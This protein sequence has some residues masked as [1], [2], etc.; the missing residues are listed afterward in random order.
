MTENLYRESK[1]DGQ[2]ETPQVGANSQVALTESA[3]ELV[4][5]CRRSSRI[6]NRFRA[7]TDKSMKPRTR[8]TPPD[9][10][11]ST[12]RANNHEFKGETSD[13]DNPPPPQT[14]TLRNKCDKTIQPEQHHSVPDAISDSVGNLPSDGGIDGSSTSFDFKHKARL[15]NSRDDFERSQNERINFP[16]SHDLKSWK[17]LDRMLDEILPKTFSKQVIKS[18]STN[19]LAT[20]FDSVLHEF[21]LNHCGPIPQESKT[22]DPEAK[23]APAVPRQVH[24]GLERLRQQKKDCRA[25]CRALKKA[26]FGDSMTAKE[27]NR[28]WRNLVR[29]HNRLRV[30]LAHKKQHK[31]KKVAERQFKADPH[32]FAQ[33]LFKE[34]ALTGSPNASAEEASSFFKDGYHDTGRGDDIKPLE[35]MERPKLPEFPFFDKP[36]NFKELKKSVSAKR[37]AATP[38]M[39]SLTYLPYKKCDS[40]LRTLLKIIRKIFDTKDVPEDWALAFIVLLQKKKDDLSLQEFRPIAITNTVGKIFF[41]IISTRLQHYLTRNNYI[42]SQIQKGF[43]SGVP[44]CVEHSFA[45]WE[46]LREAKDE[47]RAIVVSWLDLANAFG[48]VRHNLIQFALNWYHVPKSIQELIFNYYEKLC[49]RVTTKNWST[50]FFLFDIGLFQGCVLSTILFDCVFQLLLDFLKPLDKEGYKFKKVPV[51]TMKKAYADDLQITTKDPQGHQKVLDRSQV[52]FD[53]TQT[54]VAKPKKCVTVAFRQFRPGA[55]STR[56][57]K[58]VQN[59]VYSAYNPNL[60]IN[61]HPLTFILK[62]II[63]KPLEDTSFRFLGRWLSFLLN[64]LLV[65]STFRKEYFGWIA[66]VDNCP[67]NGCMKLWLYQ[68]YV[69][70]FSSWP[71]LVHDFNHNFISKN[72]QQPTNVFLRKWAGLFRSSDQGALYRPREKLGLGLTSATTY[73]RMMQTVKC[74]LLKNSKDPDIAVLYQQ[75]KEREQS[76]KTVWRATHL[77]TKVENIVDHELKFPSVSPGDRRGLGH[78]LFVTPDGTGAEHRR[79]CVAA[80]KKLEVESHMAHASSLAMQGVWTKWADDAIPFDLSWR[81][82]IWGPGPRI[83]SFVINATINSLPTPDMLKLMKL[84]DSSRCTLC[85]AEQC[86]LFHILVNCNK[87]LCGKRYTWR[88]DSVIAT[89][90]QI[91]VPWLIAQNGKRLH[92]QTLPSIPFVKA[93]SKPRKPAS[94]VSPR[95]SLLDVANDWQLLMDFDHCRMLF[96][97]EIC[98]TSERPDVVIWSVSAKTV[99]LGELTCPAEE[100]IEAAATRKESRYGDLVVLVQSQGWKCHLRTFESGARGFVAHSFRKFFKDLGFSNSE[101]VRACKKISSVTARCSYGIWLMRKTKLWNASR[102]LIVPNDFISPPPTFTPSPLLLNNR[103]DLPREIRDWHLQLNAHDPASGRRGART[104]HD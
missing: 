13:I 6:A 59:T 11:S 35:G 67:I 93:D 68:H 48:S 95:P 42:S 17:E 54:W 47:Q 94:R 27:C 63:N 38:G 30:S 36:P 89:L 86:T 81:N 69:L 83:I 70:G 85:G 9:L 91:L 15:S 37:N 97:V 62:D 33:N 104:S 22:V 26:G 45:L 103:S 40:I 28:T 34:E 23:E 1:R 76:F 24:R 10:A 53:W 82:L 65:K 7:S 72:I 61:G 43:L 74:H 14:V 71:L 58:P 5:I 31:A 60:T 92:P 29:K 55:A 84:S 18:L 75:R 80:V 16:P 88:H 12:L 51:S 49:A 100:N 101:A 96:P 19:E 39:N 57:Y 98:S 87:A 3:P 4:S 52:F 20:K 77:L 66:K 56:G 2:H 44:G 32:K 8:S 46:A 21:F 50:G 73:F 25:A 99:V 41:S 102:Q 79:L 78:D 90:L 64:E